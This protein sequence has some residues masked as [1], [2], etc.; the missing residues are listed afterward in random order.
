MKLTLFI[1]VANVCNNFHFEYFEAVE[2]EEWYLRALYYFKDF[3]PYKKKLKH[4][5]YSLNCT[6]Q[7]L[8]T[9]NGENRTF[10]QAYRLANNTKH[11]L[12]SE[13]RQLVELTLH[14]DKKFSQYCFPL[15][16]QDSE[17]NK[18]LKLASV[19]MHT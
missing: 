12:S 6:S 2:Y 18:S 1:I 11:N 9:N 7:T 15:A 8:L 19:I 4:V 5:Y 16:T 17:K 14:Y 10:T 3:Q 13:C